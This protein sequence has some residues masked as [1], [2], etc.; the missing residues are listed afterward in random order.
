[1]I[2]YR[3]RNKAKI[4]KKEAE[5]YQ[6]NKETIIKRMNG[7]YARERAIILLRQKRAIVRARR[8]AAEQRRRA[9]KLNQFVESVDPLVLLESHKG[10]CGICHKPI[11]GDF[12]VD[13][14][15]P[16]S[17]GGEHSYANTQPAHPR[18]NMKKHNS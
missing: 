3:Q 6:R 17:R 15:V 1:M 12:H 4:L 11:R 10:F 8:C 13:H 2:A 5:R 9:R 18:C 7:Y 16:L 14:I